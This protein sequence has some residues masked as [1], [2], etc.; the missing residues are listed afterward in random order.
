MS[1]D[2]LATVHWISVHQLTNEGAASLVLHSSL[3]QID[4]IDGS[5]SHG[6]KEIITN[7]WKKLD[8]NSTFT[9]HLP[10][11]TAPKVKRYALS[12]IWLATLRST[13]TYIKWLN[14]NI[15]E[16]ITLPHKKYWWN[17][18]I[19]ADLAAAKRWFI[20]FMYWSGAMA[21]RSA[22]VIRLEWHY[23]LSILRK[24]INSLFYLP[25][26]FMKIDK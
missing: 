5:S 18:M 24:C 12:K 16:I 23:E 1:D 15:F 13:G 8:L 4:W 6:Y 11:A 20:F 19:T 22:Y 3:D 2:L 9:W 21:C 7:K 10:P 17:K 14:I 26:L 25:W